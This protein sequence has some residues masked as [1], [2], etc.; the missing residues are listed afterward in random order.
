MPIAIQY[1]A[2]KKNKTIHC[3]WIYEKTCNKDLSS[4]NKCSE[5]FYKYYANWTYLISLISITE[6]TLCFHLNAEF[7]SRL[8]PPSSLPSITS[9][10]SD[11]ENTFVQPDLFFSISGQL[12]TAKISTNGNRNLTEL[13]C[14][15]FNQFHYLPLV[16]RFLARWTLTDRAIMM[17]FANGTQTRLK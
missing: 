12:F 4:C 6:G 13:N 9:F 3:V 2:Q 16:M 17:P 8:K 5:H 11:S 14:R 15:M 7:Q 1:K 10:L